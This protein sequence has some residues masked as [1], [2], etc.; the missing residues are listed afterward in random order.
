MTRI[1]KN[2]T[3]EQ[4]AIQCDNITQLIPGEDQ[5][6]LSLVFTPAQLQAC[7]TL[8]ELLGQGT[9]KYQLNDGTNDLSV[10]NAINLI[11]NIYPTSVGLNISKDDDNR[12]RISQEPRKSGSTTVIVSHNWCDP[13][14]WYTQS[15]RV[16]GETLIDSGDGYTFTSSQP[17]WIDLTHGK[18]YREDLISSSYTPVIKI[19]GYEATERIPW[20]NSGGDFTINYSDGSVT[21]FSSQSGK[22]ITADFS[23][24]NGSLFV[25]SPNNGKR[26]WVEYSEVQFSKD[27]DLTG[28]TYFQPWAYNPMDLPN[29]VPITAATIYKTFDNYIEE[30]NG[31]YPEIPAM[32]G[33][34]GILN[35]RITFPFKYSIVKELLSSF[36]V[37]IR[38]WI[39]ND[40]PFKGEYGTVTFYCTSYDE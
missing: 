26:L 36:G 19:D 13:T 2:K 7:D 16:V 28:S 27:V 8:I 1:F 9:D 39:S 22:T 17:N 4:V 12:I 15:E 35:P 25:V 14:T 34:R 10:A 32:G 31:C 3:N 21:F 23:Y 6:D 40:I 38:I 20:A 33:T 29:K 5:W 37:E 24:E 18:V 30:A 11:R